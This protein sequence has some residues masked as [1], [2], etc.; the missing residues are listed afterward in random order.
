MEPSSAEAW[1]GPRTLAPLPALLHDGLPSAVTDCDK[2]MTTTRSWQV[3]GNAFAFLREFGVKRFAM[4]VHYRLVNFYHDW[5]LRT[6]TGGMV[7]LPDIGIHNDEFIEYAP[8]GYSE[9]FYALRQIPLPPSG[10]SFLDFGSGK[11]R[12]VVAAATLPFR[13][14]LGVEISEYLNKLAQANIERMRHRKA[15]IVELIQSDAVVFPIPDDINLIY[16]ANPFHGAT[17]AKVI[18]NILASYQ[19]HPRTI[20]II[21]FNKI[22]FER[23]IEEAA[24]KLIR[25]LQVT[26]VYPNYSCGIYRIDAHEAHSSRNAS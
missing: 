14:V 8:V 2:S 7:K 24:Y 26:Q 15:G 1:L 11:G 9:I 6:D 3:L 23:L 22:H 5:R 10:T 16:M 17:L 20:H 21:Y 12:A 19:A 13:K 4:E 25:L 18:G